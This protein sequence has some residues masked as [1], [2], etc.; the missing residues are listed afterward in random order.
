MEDEDNDFFIWDED[1]FGGKMNNSIL[2]SVAVTELIY[3]IPSFITVISDDCFAPSKE[4][5][6]AVKLFDNSELNKIQKRSFMNCTFLNSINLENCKRLGCIECSAFDGCVSLTSI[7]FPEYLNFIGVRAFANCLNL[8]E[9]NQYTENNLNAILLEAFENT[10]ITNFYFGKRMGYIDNIFPLNQIRSINIHPENKEFVLLDFLLIKRTNILLSV[11]NTNSVLWVPDGISTICE[12][13]FK[14]NDNYRTVVM[15]P[16]VQCIRTEAF[17]NSSIEEIQLE[18]CNLTDIWDRCFMQT[19]LRTID[20]SE[21]KYLTSIRFGTFQD[22]KELVSL[23]A[24]PSVQYIDE[25]AFEGCS[26]LTVIEGEFSELLRIRS[27]SFA[28]TNLSTFYIP[29]LL[30]KLDF[31][32]FW[33]TPIEYFYVGKDNNEFLS[34]D[35]VLF[36][37]TAN[38]LKLYPVANRRKEY[39]LPE[40]VVSI[41][42]GA[43]MGAVFLEKI[44]FPSSLSSILSFALSNTSI[45]ILKFNSEITLLSEGSFA[46]NRNLIYVN[47]STSIKIL[48]KRLFANCTSLRTVILDHSV[49]KIRNS[50]F[51]GCYSIQC[52]SGGSQLLKHVEDPYLIPLLRPQCPIYNKYNINSQVVRPELNALLSVI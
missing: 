4:K 30:E 42:I 38:A 45:K 18:G 28:Y 32:A 46:N 17:Q 48:P 3:T 1:G 27:M 22:C 25:S 50:S 49:T 41:Q 31:K 34:N 21:Q 14:N 2:V 6:H 13:A 36:S 47:L 37:N 24:S 12:K 39:V 29:P 35:G 40:S 44:I 5:L 16:T 9:V 11:K 15:A 23:R 10:S 51:N 8:I 7:T 43:F 33:E 19:K 52:I 20:L 26:K